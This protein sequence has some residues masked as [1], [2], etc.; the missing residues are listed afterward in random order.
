MRDNRNERNNSRNTNQRVVRGS[1]RPTNN[2]N[3]R[4]SNPRNYDYY[5][6]QSRQPNR[7]RQDPRYNNSYDYPNNRTVVKR[8]RRLNKK[9][10]FVITLFILMLTAIVGYFVLF[11][12]Q[13]FNGEVG[14]LFKGIGTP[15]DLKGKQVN[16]LVLGI[17]DDP[18]EREQTRLT[19]L[20]AVV[21]VDFENDEANVLQIPRDTFI[22]DETP[23]GKMNAIYNR[24]PDYWDY[25]G[26]EG[27]SK[28]IN[29]MFKLTIDHYVTMD[30]EGFRDIVDAIGGVTMNVPADVELNGTYVYAGEQ[31]LN[32][33]QAIAVVRTRNIYSNQ[34]I[35]RMETQREFMKAFVSKVLSLGKMDIAKLAPTCIKYVNTDVT[36]NQGLKYY[37][38]ISGLNMQNFNIFSP[39][40]TPDEYNSYSLGIQDVYVLDKEATATM[41]NENF[42]K[43]T[44]PVPAEMLKIKSLE[45]Y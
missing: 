42:R 22:G 12:M 26:L 34:D 16:F 45:D 9:G 24:D 41:L 3:Q 27:L 10:K 6:R 33:D 8:K 1:S 39:E 25:H 19:D 38:A 44:E 37:K 7:R 23:T 36:L 21:S 32:G 40:G 14:G 29:E 2:Y 43:H 13:L 4:Y 30:M 20:M 17:A 31:T 28:M 18:N 15:D 11:N 35:G 5:E